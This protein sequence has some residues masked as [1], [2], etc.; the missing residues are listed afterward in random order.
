MM[1]RL[2]TMKLSNRIGKWLPMVFAGCFIVSLCD[3]LLGQSDSSLSANSTSLVVDGAILKTIESI[4]VSAQVAGVVSSVVVKEGSRVKTGTEIARIQDATVRLQAEKAKLNV[5]TATKKK[6]NN[7]DQRLALK[8]KAVAEN[9]YLRAIQANSQVKGSYSI[10]EIER[11]K[12]VFDRTVLEIE[13]ADYVHS[14]IESELSLADLEFR[15]SLDLLQR[16]R[17]YAP[18]DGVVV[19]VDKR[20]GEWVE[21]GTVLLKIIQTNQ[22]RIEGFLNAKDATPNLLGSKATVKVESGGKMVETVAELVFISPDANPLNS[23]VRVFLEVDNHQGLLRPGLRPITTV[24][25]NP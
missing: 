14:M 25:K 17:I 6:S 19:A 11:L 13:R 18:C 15:Q 4:S 16:H 23:E 20:V 12:L 8:S 2:R 22:L 10:N 7:I 1:K 3:T 21:P 24:M 5:D 9:E